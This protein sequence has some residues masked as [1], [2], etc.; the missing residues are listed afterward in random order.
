MSP[1]CRWPS[2][3][4]DLAEW[5][6]IRERLRAVAVVSRVELSELSR[7]RAQII[8]HF[9]GAPAQLVLSLAQ[10][11]LDLTW[12]DGFWTLGLSG[13][14]AVAGAEARAEAQ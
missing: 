4:R 9:L 2:P 14:A 12:D 8:L 1:A 6:A 10:N 5:L 11:D 7:N 13:A 3:L